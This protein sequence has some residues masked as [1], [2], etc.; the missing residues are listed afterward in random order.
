MGRGGETALREER[1]GA[2]RTR[3]RERE[4]QRWGRADGAQQA[5]GRAQPPPREWQ[6][7]ET[8]RSKKATRTRRAKR[9]VF[10]F[11]C[12]WWFL[13][14]LVFASFLVLSCC[15]W[16]CCCLHGLFKYGKYSRVFVL[17]VATFLYGTVPP[18]LVLSV[19]SLDHKYKYATMLFLVPSSFSPISNLRLPSAPPGAPERGRRPQP[20][21]K[22]EKSNQQGLHSS[23]H[24]RYSPHKSNPPPRLAGVG[25]VDSRTIDSSTRPI[26]QSIRRPPLSISH[27]I[28]LGLLL[29]V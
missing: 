27:P 14:L 28:R 23:Y 5:D 29:H 22:P 4:R 20:K 26:H 7:Q 19:S 9:N 24:I 10:F 21:Q 3:E 8:T 18:V 17:G 12:P 13:C 16:W 15:C 11:V 6:L 1:V 2:Q 25:S